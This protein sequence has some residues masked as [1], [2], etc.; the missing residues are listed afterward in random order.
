MALIKCGECGRS[1]SNQAASCPGCG[2]PVGLSG[3]THQKKPVTVEQTGK[4][5][6]GMMLVSVLMV[7]MGMLWWMAASSPGASAP[8]GAVLLF[9]GG[10]GLFFYSRIAGWWN[11]G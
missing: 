6:K 1:V 3:A 10:L 8:T 2:A 7:I 4:Q 11:H 5:F 9:F